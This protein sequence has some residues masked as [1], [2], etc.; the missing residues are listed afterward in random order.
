MTFDERKSLLQ[1]E[2]LS[3]RSLFVSAKSALGQAPVWR[4]RC[5]M[6]PG[7]ILEVLFSQCLQ[8]YKAPQRG[9]AAKKEEGM[10]R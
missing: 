8:L 6:A 9:R 1:P 4:E 2:P 5:W 3:I 7:I 10:G